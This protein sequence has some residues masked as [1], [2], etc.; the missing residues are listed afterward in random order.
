MHCKREERMSHINYSPAAA[1]HLLLLMLIQA[2]G[3]YIVI[4]L[5]QQNISY[6]FKGAVTREFFTV[7]LFSHLDTIFFFFFTKFAIC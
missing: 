2:A 4:V 7:E 1:C 5:Q 3:T 6:F